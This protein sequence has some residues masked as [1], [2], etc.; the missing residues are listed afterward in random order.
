MKPMKDSEGQERIAIGQRLQEE[1]QRL[2]VN[3]T[4]FGGMIGS[5]RRTVSKWELG[6]STPP[7]AM[8]GRMAAI[9]IDVFYITTGQRHH[10]HPENSLSK[11]EQELV[12]HWRRTT[13]DRRE[14]VLAVAKIAS[15][16]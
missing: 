11:K 14:T 2:G 4:V 12:D 7:T 13:E 6:E 9:G 8:L 3:Q 15:G 10:P 16:D 1:R 5:T